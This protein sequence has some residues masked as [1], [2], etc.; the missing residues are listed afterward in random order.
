MPW[1]LEKTE[2]FY[3][4]NNRF[5][6]LKY[7]EISF[8]YNSETLER[9]ETTRVEFINQGQEYKL[10]DWTKIAVYRKDLNVT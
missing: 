5:Y 6:E 4:R 10:S 8:W 9:K 2:T 1:I 7:Q 3:H